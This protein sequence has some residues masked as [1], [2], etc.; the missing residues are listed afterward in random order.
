MNSVAPDP[1]LAVYDSCLVAEHYAA[2]DYITACEQWMCDTHIAERSAVL[3]IGVGGGRVSRYLAARASRYVG[4]DYA[5]K[6]VEACRQR[7]PGLDF[8]QGEASDLSAFAGGSFDSVVMAFNTIDYLLPDAARA[9]CLEEIRRVLRPAG[10]LIFSSHNPR[11]VLVTPAWNRERLRAMAERMTGGHRSAG[12]LAYAGLTVARA[13][14]AAAQSVAASTDRILRRVPRRAFWR[15]DG[16][17]FDVAH[18]GLR[19]H[20]WVPSRCVSELARH[21]FQLLHFRADIP[22]RR[23]QQLLFADWYYY[24]FAAPAAGAAARWCA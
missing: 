7:Y 18:G 12:K 19:T 22:P 10:T 4:I 6:M 8:R 17:M 16:Y 11:A 1:N 15:G 20:Y 23:R 2:L 9:R 5:L 3:E 21:G 24:A 14:W 13:G